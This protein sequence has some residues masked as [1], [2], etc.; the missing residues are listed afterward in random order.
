MHNP[1]FYRPVSIIK[2]TKVGPDATLVVRNGLGRGIYRW[3]TS[4]RTKSRWYNI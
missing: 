4:L 3:T 2:G 1:S